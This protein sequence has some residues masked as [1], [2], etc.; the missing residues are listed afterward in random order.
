[1]LGGVEDGFLRKGGWGGLVIFSC[2]L[3]FLD[4]TLVFGEVEFG[5]HISLGQ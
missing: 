2:C 3:W 5:F 1:M 4:L